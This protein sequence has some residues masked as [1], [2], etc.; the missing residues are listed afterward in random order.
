MNWHPDR[1]RTYTAR[2]ATLDPAWERGFAGLA[3]H[4]LS[5]DLQ[6]YLGQMPHIA[7]ILARHSDV[8]VIINHL[9]MPVP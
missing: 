3:S 5:F 4:G 2:D 6:C 8:P 9:G 7:E 1:A